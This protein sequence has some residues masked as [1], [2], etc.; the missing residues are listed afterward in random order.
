MNSFGSGRRSV[1]VSCEH[2]NKPL[3]SIIKM[4]GIS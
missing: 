4:P 2:D 3:G 1:A